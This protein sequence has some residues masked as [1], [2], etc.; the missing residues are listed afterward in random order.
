MS[1]ASFDMNSNIKSS[2]LHIINLEFK[3]A[4]KL[5][6][7]ERKCNSQNG[8]IPL[9]DNYIDFLQIIINEDVLYFK[10][11]EKLKA[12][13]IQLINENDKSSPY[14]LYSKSEITLQW[15]LARLKFG[16]YAK[17]SF[18]LLK[19]YRM[20][21][22]NKHKFPEFKLNN[23]GL[24]LM[25]SLL[26]AI[27][28]EFNWLLNVADLKGDLNLGLKE[29]N[30]ILN[31]NKLSLYEEETL[32]ML[33][34]LQINLGNN[35]AV[36]RDYL[37]RIGE[38]YKDN[39]LLNFTAA[40]LSYYLGENDQCLNILSN[41]PSTE[42]LMKFYYLDY[43]EAMAYLYKLDLINSKKK[44]EYF[45][46]NF[47]GNNYVKSA[48]NN[49]AKIAFLQNNKN[50]MLSFTKNVILKGSTF[51]EVDKASFN[52]ANKQEYSHS[53]LLRA[54]LLYDGGYYTK[55]LLE[56][57]QFIELLSFASASEKSEYWYRLARIQSKLNYNDKQVVTNYKIALENGINNEE[58]YAPMSALQIG[59][60][61]EKQN[62]VFNARFFFK[63]CIS[64]SGF[65]YQRGIHQK[66]RA[67][68]S[69]VLE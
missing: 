19:A 47:K 27:P 62:D 17:A 59:I 42:K 65:D 3:E 61:Y 55:S 68:L 35:D 49:L 18:E 2:Y 39:I 60:I 40:R 10:S 32:F 30:S 22:E 38:R 51:V 1:F 4:N 58:Y 21:E 20:L 14:F 12:N 24:G 52:D 56:I 8:F 16:E 9:Y 23:K 36:C 46:H 37:D 53:I 5:L 26:G 13:R 69:R 15:A 43:L 7:I 11:H 33:S 31:D 41:R 34:F 6:D 44:F 29:L 28:D 48:Y 64:M 67:G 63:K 45:L 66:A 25:H 54:R 57:R 50:E